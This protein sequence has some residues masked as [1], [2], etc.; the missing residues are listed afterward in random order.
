[1]LRLMKP[2]FFMPVHGEFRM[3]NI[4]TQLA[5][6]VGVPKENCFIMENG[7]MLALTADTARLAGHFNA[8]DVY[9]DGSGI[10]DIG[11]VVLRDRRILSEEG[12][13]LAVATVNV[14]KKEVLAGPDILSRGF[15]Y[16]R[17]S[18]EMINEAQQILFRALR[19]V[20][21]QPD[22]TEHKLRE[23]MS[24]ALQPFLFENRASSNDP[25]DD[26]DAGRFIVS[27]ARVVLRL[28]RT[29]LSVIK[30]K[31]HRIDGLLGF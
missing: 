15:V 19:E 22:P 23:A 5:Q 29:T 20:L 28:L 17:E 2:K 12:L 24:S 26:H 31:D 4:H 14:A 3:L 6:D 30:Q 1:M 9:V 13:V 25:F 27:H 8:N 10:G 11:N 18:G 21:N 16:M 7:D